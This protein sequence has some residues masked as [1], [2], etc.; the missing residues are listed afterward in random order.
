MAL[1]DK[2]LPFNSVQ[3][4]YITRHKAVKRIEDKRRLL[5]ERMAWMLFGLKAEEQILK[6][7]PEAMQIFTHRSPLSK[8]D[9]KNLFIATYKNGHAAGALKELYAMMWGFG[10]YGFSPANVALAKKR[11]LSGVEKR[12]KETKTIRI[13]S[14]AQ[15]LVNAIEQDSV[16]IDYDYDYNLSK[17]LINDICTKEVN[18]YFH[19]L[20]QE[21]HRYVLF[22]SAI[23]EKLDKNATLSLL[24]EAKTAAVDMSNEGGISKKILTKVLPETRL[25][26]RTY[27]KELHIYHYVLENNITVD[28]KPTQLQ[29]GMLYLQAYSEGGSSVLDLKGF[30][31]I[32]HA[33]EWVGYSG[34]GDLTHTEVKKILSGKRVHVSLGIS[35]FYETLRG[36][37]SSQ[38]GA[39]MFALLYAT[40]TRPK[41]SERIFENGKKE[42]KSYLKQMHKDPDF[43]FSELLTKRYFKN[44]P[45]LKGETVAEVERLDRDEMLQYY[46]DRFSDMNH[47][48]FFIAGDADPKMVERWITRYLGNLPVQNR[49]E[50]YHAKRY[51]YLRGRQRITARLADEDTATATLSYQSSVPFSLSHTLVIDALRSILEIRLRNMIR[52]DKAGTYGVTVYTQ[53]PAELRDKAVLTV[54]FKADPT[55]VEALLDTVKKA[56]KTLR[57]EGIT[58][59][60]LA[61]FKQRVATTF[62]KAKHYNAFWLE[63][64]REHSRLGISMHEIM[65][66][67]SRLRAV[68]PKKV[69]QMAQEMLGEDVLESVML[70]KKTAEK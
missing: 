21:K 15:R 62:K 58:A 54:T 48:H 24:E 10:K 2:I 22:Q 13:D 51:D 69:Q 14:I 52:E 68:T 59:K 20:L 50:H 44:N 6:Q 57:K 41:I 43:L 19:L 67:D 9:T 70:P 3:I 7:S 64:M 60:E 49:T 18:R 40:V 27:D 56:I 32:R 11:L 66:I 28:F 47:F 37:C 1:S 12:Y 16:Y 29:K 63:M 17:K 45:R 26:S 4:G 61:V 34:P 30:R 53:T 35:R 36:A 31:S 8:T 39:S 33:A 65:D 5:V 38:D 25:R 46:K 23:Q 42:L 55:R